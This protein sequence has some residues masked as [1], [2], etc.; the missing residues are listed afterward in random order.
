M[1]KKGQSSLLQPSAL[2]PHPLIRVFCAVEL[3]TEIRRRVGDH[4]ADLRSRMPRARASWDHSEKLHLTLKFLG[5]IEQERAAFLRDAA[6][7]AARTVSP[8]NIIIEGAGTFPPRGLPR[9]LWLG[10]RD[11]SGFLAQLQLNLENECE[12]VGFPREARPFHP[13]LTIAR[14]H[15]K[16]EGARSLAAL[17]QESGFAPAEVS[18]NHLIVIRS[19]LGP[20]GSIYTE[21]SRHGLDKG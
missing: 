18:V 17:H 20:G 21:L 5:E 9:V 11:A 1:N 13:H 2:I 3:P 12:G 15:S 16:P 6:A 4:I 7:R 8:F 10:V 14:L 19:R